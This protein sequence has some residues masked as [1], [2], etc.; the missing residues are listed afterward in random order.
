MSTRTR[1]VVAGLAL[2]LATLALFGWG[3]SRTVDAWMAHDCHNGVAAA[4]AAVK[5][6]R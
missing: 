2:A 1:E 4:C 5:G 3:L 6:A